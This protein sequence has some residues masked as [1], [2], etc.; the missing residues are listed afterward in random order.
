MHSNPHIPLASSRRDFLRRS[1]CGF[2]SVAMAALLAREAQA[3][4][5]PL[6]VKPP[7]FASK[8]KRIIFLWMQGGP[9]HMDMFDFKPRLVK[10]A[11]NK[12]P[13]TL[14]KTFEAP[15]VS[16]TKVMGPLSTFS[17]K[18][19]AELLMSDWLPNLGKVSEELCVLNGMQADSEAHAPAVRQLHT[20]HTVMVRPSM[21]SWVV[22]GLGTE[23]QN[24]PGFVT[25]CPQIGGDG[26]STQLYSNAFLPA[27][28]QG[29]PVGE[30]G[31]A[32]EAQ[33]RYLQDKSISS[34]LQRRQVDLIQAINR[35]ELQDLSSDQ[36]M[37]GMIE[38]FELAFRMQ[39]EAP[40]VLDLEKESKATLDLYGIGEKE[41]DNFG[42]QCLMARRMVEAG[43]RF[44]QITDGG[45]DHHGKIKS[46]LP[47]R[48]KAIDK[49]I[50]GLILDLK[51]RGLLKDT[52]LVWS[53]EF[54]RTPFDQDL[55][56][57]KS[58]ADD[59][60]REHNPHGFTAWM[61]GG[62][63][64]GGTV[65]GQTD[66]FG[67]EAVDGRVHI[68]DLH[69]TALHLLGLDHERLTFRYTGRD[70]RL[71]DVYGTVVK[72]VLA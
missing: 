6:A 5:G 59:R 41:T 11:G 32:K 51:A 2:G 62:G 70:F 68:H 45:W 16:R 72:E 42:R 55:S 47:E 17:R 64:K 3:D 63:V 27:V 61:A 67:W 53:G 37:E 44:V 13:I 4:T 23:N 30:A 24:L 15:G 21:G 71:T 19:R 28:Y 10:E 31:N 69:A 65:Y 20:G 26:G 50:A 58:S 18:G 38:S 8:A 1:A 52:L 14:P 33:I 54:G 40:T 36:N 66:E 35:R 22:Y 48:C 46:L 34:S 49:P 7:H 29:T 60:G 43:V 25:V 56:E 9:S 12:F 57:G 39:M